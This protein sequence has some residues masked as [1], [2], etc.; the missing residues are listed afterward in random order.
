MQELTALR[1]VNR[2]ISGGGAHRN[3]CQW[4]MQVLAC[5]RNKVNTSDSPTIILSLPHKRAIESV[6]LFQSD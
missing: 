2:G 3:R 4:H 6:G 5:L 1:Q